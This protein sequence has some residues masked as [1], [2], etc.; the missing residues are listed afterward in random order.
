MTSDR[1]FAPLSLVSPGAFGLR[2]RALALSG[3][4]SP[5][6]MSHAEARQGQLQDN[7]YLAPLPRG[8]A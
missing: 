3:R 5:D 8:A 2:V 4:S 1:Q 7:Q 6:G